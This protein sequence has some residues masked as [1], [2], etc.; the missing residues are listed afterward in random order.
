MPAICRPRTV[1]EILLEVFA[2]GPSLPPELAEW[3]LTLHISDEEKARMVDLA[4]RGNAG[5]LSAEEQVEI[6]NYAQAGNV[7]S[8]L[9]AKARLALRNQSQ[10]A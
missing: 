1:A 6:Q 4:E 7:L 10:T 8:V 5:T 3:I 9:H 2:G